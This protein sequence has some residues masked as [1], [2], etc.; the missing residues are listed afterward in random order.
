MSPTGLKSPHLLT[1]L[2]LLLAPLFG[3][4]ACG[5]GGGSGGS[6]STGGGSA[7]AIVTCSLG[8]SGGAGGTQV[9]CGISNIAV[10]QEIIVEF[11]Q[12]VDLS[13][14]TKNTFQV[15]NLVTGKTPAGTFLLD[16]ANAKRLIF[17][18]QLTFDSNGNPVFGLTQGEAYQIR[19]P[20]TNQDPTGPYIKS[21]GGANNTSRLQCP[22]TA[23]Q[24]I[25]DLAPGAPTVSVTVDV[26][27]GYD[28]ITGEPNSFDFNVPADGAVDVWRD[29]QVRL[30]FDDI[31]NPATVVNPVT[32][33][34]NT[35]RILVDPDGNTNDTADQSELFG[36]FQIS[37]DQ[38]ALSTTVIF[39]PATGLP[40]KGTG[41]LPR[42]IVVELPNQILDLGGNTLSNTGDQEFIPEFIAFDELVLPDGT[43]E[44]FTDTQYQ[45]VKRSGLAWGNGALVLGPGGGSGRLGDIDLQPG[46]VLEL[47]TDNTEFDDLTTIIPVGPTIPD[48]ELGHTETVTDGIFEFASATIRP[49]S[50]LRFKGS[51]PAR[52]FVRGQFL[53]QGLLD[54]AGGTAPAQQSWQ[55]DTA[56][57]AF[58]ATLDGAE[59][60]V[61]GP[62][63]GDGGRGGDRP[64]NTGTDLLSLPA[65]ARGISN[66]GA[67]IDATSGEGVGGA[68]TAQAGGAGGVHWPPTLPT[69]IAM[70]PLAPPFQNTIFFDAVCKV[71]TVA[72]RGSGGGYATA[73][74]QPIGDSPDGALFNALVLDFV[75]HP[76]LQPP[77]VPGGQPGSIPDLVNLKTMNADAGFLRGGSGGGGGGAHVA[78]T[79]SGGAFG[80]CYTVPLIEYFSHKGGGGGGGGGAVQVQA[81][82]L[83][84]VSGVI[85]AVGGSGSSSTQPGSEAPEAQ[86]TPGGGGSGGAVLLQSLSVTLSNLPGRIDVSGGS[87]GLTGLYLGKAAGKGGAGL[88][89]VETPTPL[90]PLVEAPKLLPFSTTSQEFGGPDSDVIFSAAAWSIKNVGPSALSGATSCWIRPEGNFFELQFLEDD[91]VAGTYGWDM[92]AVINFPGLQP[93]SWRDADDPNNPFGV[94]LE[95]LIGTDLGGPNKSPVVVRFQGARAVKP[96]NGPCTVNLE[97][98]LGPVLP[99]SVTGWVRHPAELNGYFDYLPNGEGA[100]LRPNMIRYQVI[101]DRST[102]LAPGV[103]QGITDLR[104]RA[105]PD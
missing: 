2:A 64:D 76:F 27:T 101:F 52:L 19:I 45:D 90:N 35:I 105:Q 96:L 87:G 8:C 23:S 28:P 80:T 92:K 14:V 71:P 46:E 57:A 4:T 55:L 41:L 58:L 75:L 31:M 78:L 93:V 59:G 95:D 66:P 100:K 98:P 10:N 54:A 89:R 3:L 53:L 63:A 56:G 48:P 7:M 62:G 26:V 102:G 84:N 43:G 69:S 22:V 83:I 20:G 86:L 40:S 16:P 65:T 38:A 25:N 60:G 17:R 29:T 15:V 77:V 32:G 24:G 12:P 47:D 74:G 104:I 13:S 88:I 9:S 82:Q 85:N 42:Q 37:L 21:Q 51:Q 49:G 94:S 73:G 18:P 72:A 81:G 36:T 50:V 1:S 103:F 91:L 70:P 97:D 11:T 34:S 68:A 61:G 39:T 5:S 6:P 67:V 79:R 44:Q 33:L 30:F 99:E